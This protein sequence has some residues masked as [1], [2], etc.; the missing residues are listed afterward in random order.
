MMN[1]ILIQRLR[2]LKWIQLKHMTDLLCY[3]VDISN[4][5]VWMIFHRDVNYPDY[6]VSTP[7]RLSMR[8]LVHFHL[9]GTLI[10]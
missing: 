2:H 3:M 7:Q 9:T 8:K 6:S 10:E 5:D 1:W 4:Q